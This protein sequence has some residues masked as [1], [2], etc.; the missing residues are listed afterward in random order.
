MSQG[1][2]HSVLW[3]RGAEPRA[4]GMRRH[5]LAARNEYAVKGQGPP[6]A[7]AA[8]FDRCGHRRRHAAVPNERP[9]SVG[10]ARLAP[11]GRVRS[12]CLRRA[13]WR[14]GAS[15]VNAHAGDRDSQR[16]AVPTSRPGAV[17]L[18]VAGLHWRRPVGQNTCEELGGQ[19]TGRDSH[20]A[21]AA[22]PPPGLALP[23]HVTP[24]RDAH[25]ARRS[26]DG[27]EPLGVALPPACLASRW[28]G[29]LRFQPANAQQP[30][31]ARADL[32]VAADSCGEHSAQCSAVCSVNRMLGLED[33]DHCRRSLLIRSVAD[34]GK[35]HLARG[36][37]GL[38]EEMVH[39]GA[40]SPA[41]EET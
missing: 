40:S 20:V 19:C 4:S 17:S 30:S 29:G 35:G 28:P 37:V 26:M 38:R 32:C 13:R 16:M 11:A 5:R 6:P 24:T 36:L 34:G 1:Q 27:L 3:L 15:V 12:S 41:K 9:R 33:H 10:R 23:A 39:L 25:Q 18:A 2:S 8:T 14:D 21:L 31:S 7:P 22:L